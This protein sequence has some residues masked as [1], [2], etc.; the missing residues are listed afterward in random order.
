MEKTS[1]NAPL[2]NQHACRFVFSGLEP[3]LLE[4]GELF[5]QEFRVEDLQAKKDWC[6]CVFESFFS[7]QNRWSH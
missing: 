3:Q 5:V 7:P 2:F 1:Q 4:L 6:F